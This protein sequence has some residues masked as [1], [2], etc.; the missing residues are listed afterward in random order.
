[1][2]S[3]EVLPNSLEHARCRNRSGRL[4]GVA[5]Y[6]PVSRGL[7]NPQRE[8]GLRP[9][10]L[11]SKARHPRDAG[12]FSCTEDFSTRGPIG[13]RSTTGILSLAESPFAPQFTAD[14]CHCDV[15]LFCYASRIVRGQSFGLKDCRRIFLSPIFLSAITK[16]ADKKMGDKKMR[17]KKLFHSPYHRTS[18]HTHLHKHW[19]TISSAVW[20][21]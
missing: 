13:L 4:D 8:R 14:T 12:L 15:A 5:L 10:S 9:E 16:N 21:I 7:R 17:Q 11:N 3:E 1:M 6:L 18:W 20:T 2:R 19:Q